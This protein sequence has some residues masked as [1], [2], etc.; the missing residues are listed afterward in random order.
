MASLKQ[1]Q[2]NRRNALRST[3]PSSV[4]GKAAVRLNALKSGIDAQSTIIYG[5]QTAD[6]DALTA[7]Y[8]ADFAPAD[9]RE[10]CY[11]DILIRADWQLR[12]LARVEAE[13]WEYRAENLS[14]IDPTFPA[15]QVFYYTDESFVRLQRRISAAERSYRQASRE[16]D[17][18]R[19]AGARAE[20]DPPPQPVAAETSC[21]A[22]GFV[23]PIIAPEARGADHHVCAGPPGP[24]VAAHPRMS[25]YLTAACASAAC[26]LRASALSVAS[27]VKLSP[28][29]PK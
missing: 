23:P 7:Q 9:P 26:S 1:I 10:R 17:L 24:A 27:Q 15:G 28:V 14:E 22:I 12:R 16:L 3:G 2:A 21:P 29:R 11:V 19:Q 25:G 18:L 5:E 4:A 8:L 20:P 13:L 6:L